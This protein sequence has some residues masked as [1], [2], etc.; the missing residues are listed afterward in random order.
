MA[1]DRSRTGNPA[2]KDQRADVDREVLGEQGRPSSVDQPGEAN[3]GEP[4]ARHDVPAEVW[5]HGVPF[6]RAH[7][8]GRGGRG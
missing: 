3:L 5:R 8:R 7:P 2:G 6:D 4:R 1:D